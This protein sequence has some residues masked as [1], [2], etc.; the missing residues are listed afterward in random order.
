MI[1]KIKPKWLVPCITMAVAE[2]LLNIQYKISPKIMLD[3][4]KNL[5]IKPIPKKKKLNRILIIFQSRQTKNIE[6]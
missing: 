4:F 2:Y 5:G 1:C 3:I 6:S